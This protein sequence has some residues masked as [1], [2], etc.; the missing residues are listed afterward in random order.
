MELYKEQEEKIPWAKHWYNKCEVDIY[1][2]TKEILELNEEECKL[3]EGKAVQITAIT[4]CK[5]HFDWL[6]LGKFK[7]TLKELITSLD[8]VQNTRV[9]LMKETIFCS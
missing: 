6:R 9:I 3:I 4:Y 5:R 1:S 7:K 2:L 8:L